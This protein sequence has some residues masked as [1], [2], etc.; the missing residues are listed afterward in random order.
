MLIS[1]LTDL[2]WLSMWGP[3]HTEYGVHSHSLTGDSEESI[4]LQNQFSTANQTAKEATGILSK[5]ERT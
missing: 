1:G 3:L 5:G 4:E 2:R